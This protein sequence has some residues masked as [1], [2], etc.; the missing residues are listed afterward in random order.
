MRPTDLDLFHNNLAVVLTG[1]E[2]RE[3]ITAADQRSRAIIKGVGVVML[4]RF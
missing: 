1:A 4:S 3:I 2:A